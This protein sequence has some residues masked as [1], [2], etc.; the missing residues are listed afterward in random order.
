[1]KELMTHFHITNKAQAYRSIKAALDEIDLRPIHA[2]VMNMNMIDRPVTTE[3]GRWFQEN[4][5]PCCRENK[6]L[7]S[8]LYHQWKSGTLDITHIT[9]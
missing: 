2:W 3:F 5:G 1:M 9:L 6:K 7:Y 8:R 4:Y